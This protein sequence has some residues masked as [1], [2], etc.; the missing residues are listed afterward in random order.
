M[1]DV[2]TIAKAECDTVEVPK[3][4]NC[5][6]YNT[7]FYGREVSGPAYP[8]CMAFVQWCF[9]E[10]GRPLPYKTASCSD[11]LRWYR[12][13]QPKRVVKEPEPGDIVI[14]NFG[15]TG[16]VYNTASTFIST[17]EGNTDRNGSA[18]GGGV[19][20]R[21]RAKSLVTAY[22]RPEPKKEDE[23]V[24]DPSKITDEQM[25]E[26]L[27]RL[28]NKVSDAEIYDLMKRGQAY[29]GNLDTPD[30]SVDEFAAAVA[31]GITDGTRPMAFVT[32]LEAALM[33]LRAK[34]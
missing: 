17:V 2:V 33:A 1:I 12:E 11:L 6:K 20:K 7:W 18:N 22:I 14:F 23:E 13:N 16:I 25:G 28:L 5:V 9:N 10:A 26:I 34:K 3:G 32:R 19:L 15:H 30:W 24:F 21:Q 8:W 27:M 31:K 4:S 29:A